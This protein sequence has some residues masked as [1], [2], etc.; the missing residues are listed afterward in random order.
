MPVAAVT[1]LTSESM[2]AT[3]S[4]AGNFSDQHWV[5]GDTGSVGN[6]VEITNSKHYDYQ[7]FAPPDDASLSIGEHLDV[8]EADEIYAGTSAVA[9]GGQ[10]VKSDISISHGSLKD[11]SNHASIVNGKATTSQQCSSANGIVVVTRTSSSDGTSTSL[12]RTTVTVGTITGYSD[13]AEITIESPGTYAMQSGRIGLI[14]GVANSGFTAGSY[15]NSPTAGNKKMIRTDDYGNKYDFKSTSSYEPVTEGVGKTDVQIGY[16]VDQSDPRASQ[17]QGAADAAQDGDSINVAEGTYEENLNINKNLK[18]I[19]SGVGKT[20]VDGKGKGS[21]VKT[22]DGA[23]DASIS[24]LTLTNGAAELG[25]GINHGGKKL[26]ADNVKII[27]CQANSNGGAVYVGKG[28]SLALNNIDIQGCTAVYGGAGYNDGGQITFDGGTISGNT[29]DYGSAFYNDNCGMTDLKSG[30]ITGN[31]AR[32]AD[33]GA[34][35]NK[36]GKITGDRT[37]VKDGGITESPNADCDK[38]IVPDA[39]S[40]TPW[41]KTPLGIIG[42]VVVCVAV[43]ALLGWGAFALYTAYSASAAATATAASAA[44]ASSSS[45]GS[46]PFVALAAAA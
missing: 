38:P 10:E 12:A 46:V 33:G 13:K 3:I 18:I 37:I 19:G 30:S 15:L 24:H 6:W 7:Y 42:I 8:D 9:W 14:H 40:D 45:Y 5:N 29:A 16:Y 1:E 20:V 22:T 44:A 41:Y 34:V 27:N 17:I 11:Y 23:K 32:K 2:R 39:P 36:R 26:T 35:Y 21:V 25:A 28:N 43:A 31:T 4:G